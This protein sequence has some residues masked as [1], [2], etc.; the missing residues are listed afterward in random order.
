MVAYIVAVLGKRLPM[1]PLVARG[2]PHRLIRLVEQCFDTD[3]QRRPA[4]SDLVKG[5]LL[6]QEQLGQED[7][8]S[9]AVLLQAARPI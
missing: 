5:L 6:V 9:K 1:E 3:P 7:E 4:A 8:V 2:A